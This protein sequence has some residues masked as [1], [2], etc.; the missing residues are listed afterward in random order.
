MHRERGQLA[1]AIKGHGIVCSKGSELNGAW[2]P[3]AL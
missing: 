3:P 1:H 2:E